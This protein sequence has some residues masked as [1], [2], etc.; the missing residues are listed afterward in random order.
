MHCV[1]RAHY[2]IAPAAS[3]ND[4]FL[5][6]HYFSSSLFYQYQ[7]LFV[8]PAVNDYWKAIQKEFWQESAWK[9]VI[10]SRD[11]GNDSPGHSAQYCTYTP[12]DIETKL[13]C[14][15]KL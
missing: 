4:V 5:N 11:G 2:V 3:W 9:E 15:W 14:T 12:A 6:L 10:L 13:F 1:H 7:N 8:A